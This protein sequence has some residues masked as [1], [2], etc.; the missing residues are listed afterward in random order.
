MFDVGSYVIYRAEGVCVISDIREEN[1]GAIGGNEKY[2]ILSPVNDKK[3]TVYV[4]VNNKM[5]CGMMR[6]LLSAEQINDLVD[7]LRCER[8]EWIDES[9]ARNAAFREV[10]SAGDR[11]QLIVLTN[12][13]SERI[14]EAQSK[15][16]K[17]TSTDENA[18]L[19][20]KK[21]LYEEFRETSDISSEEDI[22]P[23]LCGELKLNPKDTE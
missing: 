13:V 14:A 9:R 15:G 21:M 3:S 1:F 5:L 7:E 2:Y 11:R 6:P 16:R 10:L 17:P 23:L 4:P 22:I 8:M 20:A 18:I 12:T 19:R